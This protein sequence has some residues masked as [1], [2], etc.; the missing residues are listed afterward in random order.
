MSEPLQPFDHG[1]VVAEEK[2][3]FIQSFGNVVAT[4]FD[5][6]IHHQGVLKEDVIGAPVVM[7]GSTHRLVQPQKAFSTGQR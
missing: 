3:P 4:F 1:V 7:G 5:R 6:A 2:T